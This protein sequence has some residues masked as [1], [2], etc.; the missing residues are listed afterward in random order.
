MEPSHLLAA[1]RVVKDNERVALEI[2]AHAA[3]KLDTLGK[4][5]FEQLSEFEK[6][7]YELLTA[8]EKSLVEKGEFIEYEGKD[9]ILPTKIE[10]KFT[11]EPGQISIVQIVSEAMKLEKKA[12]EDYADI[13]NK[14][15]DPKGQK[16]FLKL[17]DDEH[18]HFLILEDAYWSLNQTGV[19]KYPRK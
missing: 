1:V 19:W 2:Y 7:H 12:Q 8:L 15:T 11:E 13:A 16:M 18:K 3:E 6:F 10:L 5:L 17:S 4:K 9:F 14:L